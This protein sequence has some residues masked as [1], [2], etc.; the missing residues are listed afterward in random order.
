MPRGWKILLADSGA[1]A[2]ELATALR[3]DCEV[4][5][6]TDA[7]SVLTMA[8]RNEP[9]AA[10]LGSRLVAGG[11]V[12][13]LRRLRSSAHTSGIPIIGLAEPGAGKQALLAAGAEACLDLP[14]VA[15]DVLAAL[16]AHLCRPP[17]VQAPPPEILS[18]PARL[19]A[20]EKTALMDTEPE[21]EF[22]IL[23][24]LAARLLESPVALV[25][26]VDEKRQFFKSQVGLPEPWDSRRQTPL[27]HSFCQWVVSSDE[28]LIVD[29]AR[30]H[31]VLQS[32]GAVSDLGVVAYAGVPLSAMTGEVIGSFCAID[33]K[34]RAWSSS[35]VATL[36]DLGQV[37][38]AFSALR[39]ARIKG[40]NS[41]A[42]ARAAAKGFAGASRLLRRYAGRAEECAELVNTIERHAN[43]LLGVTDA[44]GSL[45]AA[46]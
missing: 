9:Q 6:A 46:S 18:R 28:E 33:G 5:L 41:G 43:L 34:P 40:D 30:V 26:L 37:V 8:L 3:R 31:P 39:Q 44:P 15:S 38:D 17:R 29:D 11:P 2:G 10:I 21:E 22:D 27:S 45:R 35:E 20:L 23:T 13:A 32:N 24:R 19:D 36:R 7:S 14:V 12:V 42:T 25:S 4:I 1:G 16:E